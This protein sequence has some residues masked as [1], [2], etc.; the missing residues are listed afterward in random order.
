MERKKRTAYSHK[1]LTAP[2]SKLGLK[3]YIKTVGGKVK[4]MIVASY[5]FA[6]Q[7]VTVVNKR[8][9]YIT[10]PQSQLITFMPYFETA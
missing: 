10:I 3:A 4:T 2:K 5:D 9:E 1:S 7:A 8:G 6:N